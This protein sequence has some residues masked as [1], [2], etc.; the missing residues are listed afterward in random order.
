M[1]KVNELMREVVAE[2]VNELKDPRIG[3]V[4]I[5]G[6]DTAPDLRHAVVYYSVLGTTE[7]EEATAEALASAAARMQQAVGSQTRLKFTPKLDFAV[8]P[9]IRGGDR[10]DR[11]LHEL[12]SDAAEE[13]S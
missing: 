6:V 2:A 5:T 3:F 9:S 4:T 1:Y 13:P 7:E 10:I 11:I 12:H 8:D